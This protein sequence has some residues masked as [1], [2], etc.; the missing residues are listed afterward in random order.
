[1]GMKIND[2][3]Y[4]VIASGAWAD[5]YEYELV[6]DKKYGYWVAERGIMAQSVTTEN[7]K[8]CIS[9]INGYVGSYF[10]IWT[11]PE[12]GLVY[13]DKTYWVESLPVALA[14][15]KG[16]GQK[17]IWDIVLGEALPVEL[18]LERV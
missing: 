6:T 5:N 11:D 17:A 16:W 18:E 9:A 2:G 14:A 1:M 3:T 7:I 8:G 15:A 12:S 4:K 13:F 10:G